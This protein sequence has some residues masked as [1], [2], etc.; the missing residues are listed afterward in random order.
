ME[1]TVFFIRC[2]AQVMFFKKLCYFIPNY[3]S[4]IPLTCFPVFARKPLL[5]RTGNTKKSFLWK[6]LIFF[7]PL[8]G[9]N[10][11]FKKTGFL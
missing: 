10:E 7:L 2:P 1:K 4:N 8:S 11:F 9:A 6:T 5:G 3:K